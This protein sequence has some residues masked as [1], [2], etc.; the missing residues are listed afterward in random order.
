MNIRGCKLPVAVCAALLSTPAFAPDFSIL[1]GDTDDLRAKVAADA[2][3]S[4]RAAQA[5]GSRLS[6]VER[7]EL[8]GSCTA[9]IA[10]DGDP[11]AQR[12]LQAQLDRYK[13][14]DPEAVLRFCLD[15]AYT[16]LQSELEASQRT[17]RASSA[18]RI[19]ARAS[20]SLERSFEEQQR[21]YTA[22]SNVMKTRHD[23]VKNAINNVR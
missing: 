17:L 13:D 15:P 23:T 19:D 18:D 6:A 7:R 2:A 21:K 10:N 12:S 3:R 11:S 4:A 14:N 20:A 16:A 5:F 9:L 22:I 1:L 8:Q